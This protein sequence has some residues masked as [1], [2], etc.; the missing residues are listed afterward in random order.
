MEELE[1]GLKDLRGFADPW[2]RATVST[3]QTPPGLLGTGPTTKN[4]TWRDPAA[5]VEEKSLT[6]HKWEE[7]PFSLRVFNAPV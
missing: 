6:G 2:I 5:Y 3:G 7:Q 4:Y 1:K